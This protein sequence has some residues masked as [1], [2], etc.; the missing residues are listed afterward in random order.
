M[1]RNE[2]LSLQIRTGS[3]VAPQADDALLSLVGVAAPAPPAPTRTPSPSAGPVTQSTSFTWPSLG[4]WRSTLRPVPAPR[5]N[6]NQCHHYCVANSTDS[7]RVS[8]D[9]R[10]IPKSLYRGDHEGRIGDY[11]TKFAGPG[12]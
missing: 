6:G 3:Q 4:S 10:V 9:L 1:G 2:T 12:A 7:T 8:F 11:K 5:F